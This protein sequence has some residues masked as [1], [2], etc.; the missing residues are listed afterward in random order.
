MS[1]KAQRQ[2]TPE[3]PVR[4]PRSDRLLAEDPLMPSLRVQGLGL[5]A[6]G[7]GNWQ[8]ESDKLDGKCRVDW[9]SGLGVLGV[10]GFRICYGM[11]LGFRA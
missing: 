7:L 10:H 8:G 9:Y 11:V 1:P 4:G 2:A 3:T 6:M 5:R